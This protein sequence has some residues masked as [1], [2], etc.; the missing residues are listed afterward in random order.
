MY[1]NKLLNTN[2]TNIQYNS[3]MT[4]VWFFKDNILKLK[5]LIN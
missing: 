5:K 1:K 4:F 2:Y 3:V